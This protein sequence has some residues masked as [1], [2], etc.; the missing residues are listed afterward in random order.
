MDSAAVRVSQPDPSL[1]N[2][3]LAPV[4]K[5]K[6]TWD[7]INY[8]TIWMGMVHNIVSYEL[9]ASLLSI[10]MSVW[11]ALGAVILSNVV[12]IAVVW[13][14]S[15]AGTKYG[16]PFPV[17]IRASFGYRGAH[18]PV[19]IRAFIGIFWFAAQAYAGSKAVGAIITVLYPGWASLGDIMFLGMGLQDW[20]GFAV[21]WL[22]HAWVISHGMERVRHFEMWAGPLVIVLGFG[23]VGWAIKVAHGVG[24][25]FAIQGTLSGGPFWN[26]FFLSVT[27]LIGVLA[28]LVLNIPDL[29]RYSRSQ[30]DQV[31]GQ[32]IGLPVM[33]TV[34]AFMSILI[35]AGTIVA[36]GKPI[37]NPVEILLQF[38]NP[39][40]ILLGAFSLLVATLSVN[41]VA[42]VVSPAY[43]LVNLLPSKLNFVQ[44]GMISIIIG[45]FF[46]PWLWFD[47][48]GT[49]Y[50]ILGA[51]GGTLGPVAGIMITDYYWVRGRQYN[52]DS[53]FSK[54]G[55]F[56][57]ANGW[58]PQAFIALGIGVVAA[59]IGL[60]VPA[61]AAVYTYN[62]FVGI[63]VGGLAYTF[64]MRASLNRS[65]KN[66]IGGGVNTP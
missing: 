32:A 25:L 52:V 43:D 3:D 28:T 59:L 2:E 35:T 34:F 65:M 60:F 54:E 8:S 18:I 56:R 38:K 40:V 33:M 30:K 9:A 17:L 12:L 62:W 46:A 47:N 57:Y 58:N 36:F 42:N 63:V 61:L 26:S 10:G 14:N 16:L 19:M 27:G 24:P 55:E 22:L 4:P 50:M 31:L 29:T 7:W 39:F 53:F 66:S 5:E 45:L 37:T 41:I 1:Y 21:F 49:I 15:V 44:A 6:R 23:L 48:A 51:I 11:Q 13:L 20:I 64:L